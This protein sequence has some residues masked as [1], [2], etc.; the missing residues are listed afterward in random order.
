MY[1]LDR[2]GKIIN[3]KFF[4]FLFP[5]VLSTIAISLNEFVDSII[6]SQLLGTGA[7]SMVNMGYPVM[8]AYAVF[9]TLLGV[10]GSV[11]YGKL[12]GEQNMDRAGRIFSVTFTAAL[13]VSVLVSAAG[14]IFLDPLSRVLCGHENLLEVFRPYLRFVLYSGVLIIPIQVIISFLTAFGRP[15]LGTAVNITANGV[16]LVLDYVYIRFLGTNLKGA[17]M[18]TFS[19]YAVGLVM[20]LIALAVGK[21]RFPFRRF[22]VSDFRKLPSILARGGAPALNQFGYCVKTAFCNSLATAVAGLAGVAVFT[23]C[24][25]AVSIASIFIAG[26]ICAMLPIA[27]SL[28]G[29]RDYSGIRILLSTVLKLQFAVNAAIVVVLELFPQLILFLY[30]VDP[31]YHDAAVT[32]LRI[33]SLMFI[34]RGFVMLW[35]Y[36]FQVSNRK[37]YAAVI[38]ILD[39]FAGI[40]PLSLLLTRFWG[41]NGLWASFPVLSILMLAGILLVNSILSRKHPA[42]YRGLLLLEREDSSVP[43]FDSSCP[44]E[45]G[46]IAE[47]AR[48]LQAFCAEHIRDSRLAALAALAAEEMSVY[49]MSMKAQTEVDMLDLL[50]KIDPDE[51]LMDF[52]TMGKPFD[53]S[54]APAE[55]FSS[56]DTLKKIASSV[57]YVYNIGLNQT[58]IRISRNRE[59][60]EEKEA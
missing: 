12:A 38:G 19:G 57:E 31:A 35:M 10:G 4:H 25:Q 26:I 40:I 59:N 43:V 21:V 37:V 22:P 13:V 41:I 5:T 55:P 48:R 33:F 3:R 39:A 27:A 15:G 8:L 24:M 42:K 45:S 52:R 32:G 53:L 46:A 20:I 1:H 6:V 7:M 29:Q 30:N 49:S 23:L 28:Q 34:F 18:A 58:R 60:Q 36:Y 50:V 9:Y 56:A 47:N 51:I 16:N 14:L 2:S 11:L 17:A 54:S 44:L